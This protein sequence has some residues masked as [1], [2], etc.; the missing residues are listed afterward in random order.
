[1]I[2]IS[3]D[4]WG[5][6]CWD[7]NQKVYHRGLE[8]LLHDAGHKVINISQ[9]GLDLE[10]IVERLS[11]YLLLLR[12]RPPL[13]M[14]EPVTKIFVM[15]TEWHRLMFKRDDSPELHRYQNE[16][17]D[18]KI[19][20]IFY[21]TLSFLATECNVDIHIIGG[22]SDT[23]WI[24][25]FSKFYPGVSIACQS[26]TNLLVNDNHRIDNP[27]FSVKFPKELLN[28]E[29]AINLAMQ[30]EKREQIWKDNPEWM[31]PDGSHP[32]H[33]GHKKL[34]EHIKGVLT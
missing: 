19:I 26:F 23:I 27:V 18:Q 21:G 3:G 28:T 30:G 6:G 22:C 29:D 2:V 14:D 31:W 32:N 34:Y 11:D 24:D 10:S 33:L 5:C 12:D 16:G 1:M 17:D 25:D 15:Q 13:W 20:A 8:Q 4:S 9:G 7:T